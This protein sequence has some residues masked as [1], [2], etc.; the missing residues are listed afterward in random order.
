MLT[1]KAATS[2]IKRKKDQ[3]AETNKM[4]ERLKMD[5]KKEKG[6][7]KSLR[8]HTELSKKPISEEKKKKI[9]KSKLT[10]KNVS[11]LIKKNC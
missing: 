5:L 7:V 6:Y 10:Q 8:N 2:E 1:A 3:N 4:R 9:L 11:I